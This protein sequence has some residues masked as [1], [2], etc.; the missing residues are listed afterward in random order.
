MVSLLRILSKLL[1]ISTLL[2]I[3]AGGIV[4][5][6]NVGLAVP[7]WPTSFGY[8]MWTLPWTLWKGGVLYEHAHRVIASV[9]GLMTLVLA[10][11]VARC[12]RR[13]W[14]RMLG[15]VA[16]VVV[17]IQGLLGAATVH[18]LLP[19]A[20]SVS[21]GI[22]AQSFFVVTVII[23]YG[24]SRERDRRRS[25]PGAVA[26]RGFARL[27]IVFMIILYMQLLFG[28]MM[29]HGMK[30]KGGVAVPEFPRI[31]SSW[32]P[33]FNDDLVERINR[34]RMDLAW[35]GDPQI[36]N[37]VT[38]ADIAIHALHRA[39]AL[40]VLAGALVLTWRARQPN[41]SARVRETT[42]WL[43]GFIAIQI[44]LGIATVITQR[45]QSLATLHTAT[46]AAVLGITTLL[47]LRAWPVEPARAAPCGAG[48]PHAR[49]SAEDPAR[50]A[51]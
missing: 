43:D 9:V 22:L 41:I 44:L 18:L 10:V 14:L 6:M 4:T 8:S 5:T 42:L 50:L 16:L 11:G 34:Q 46:G 28:A 47:V 19:T 12:E 51:T 38:L 23:A 40:A 39:G 3:V 26:D 29:R 25:E 15:A 37:E 17:V 49:P 33:D 27:V 20:V 13:E 36:E 1:C 48:A 2:L 32:L 7:T 21:H 45:G 30:H 31:G 35:H 24:L